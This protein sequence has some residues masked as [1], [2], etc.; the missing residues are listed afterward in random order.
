[1]KCKLCGDETKVTFTIKMK[2]EAV[3]DWCARSITKQNIDYL[4]ELARKVVD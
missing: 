1:M 2:Q 3:C 4:L